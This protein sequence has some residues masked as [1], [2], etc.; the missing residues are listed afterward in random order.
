M[1][2]KEFYKQRE[3][4]INLYR[5]YSNKDYYIRKIGTE[6]IYEEAIDVESSPYKYEETDQ[7]IKREE[8]I[9]NS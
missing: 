3:D 2:V 6:E 5:T 1:I 8:N 9:E 7:K 4:G